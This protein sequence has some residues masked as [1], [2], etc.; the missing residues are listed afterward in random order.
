MSGRKKTAI[1][2][3][4]FSRLLLGVLTLHLL[5]GL[6]SIAAGL[7]NRKNARRAGFAF[8]SILHLALWLAFGVGDPC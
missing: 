7:L 4:R 3:V 6:I 1:Y 5:R 2:R 8:S